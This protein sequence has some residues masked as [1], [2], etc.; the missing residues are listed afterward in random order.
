[1]DTN[2]QPD[3]A[4]DDTPKYLALAEA[5]RRDVRASLLRPG[6][7]LPPVRD[8]AWRIGVTPGTVARAYR[9]GIDQGLLTASVGRGTFV[10]TPGGDYPAG[11]SP[12]LADS[13]PGKLDL[14]ACVTPGVGQDA[15]IAEGLARLS[16]TRGRRYVE[17]PRAGLDAEARQA[18]CDWAGRNGIAAEPSD[19][20][21][22]YGAQNAVTVALQTILSGP[23]PV[24]LTEEVAFPGMR[25]AARILRAEIAGV[26]Q[27]DEG[28]VPEAI[29]A[30]CRKLHPQV[31]LTSSGAHNP[32]T[33]ETSAARRAEIAELARRFD[34][35]IVEDDAYGLVPSPHPMYRSL[36][37][38]RVWYAASLTKTVAAGLRFGYLVCPP[39]RGQAARDTMLCASYGLSQIVADL[40]TELITSGQADQFRIRCNAAIAARVR[41]TV[42]ALGK[43][44]IRWREDAPFCWLKLPSGWRA[45]GFAAAC[46]RSGIQIRPADEFVLS[47]GHAPNAV[48]IAV[49][50]NVAAEDFED[51]LHTLAALLDTPSLIR[52]T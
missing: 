16:A 42:E 43:W 19:V 41:L 6:D 15:A 34:F 7:K 9:Q 14:R 12:A 45:S 17:H 40:G 46:D 10:S 5:I 32:T 3:L 27:D 24:I 11:G 29:E 31:F 20:A 49:N 26:A 39:G 47:D 13:D 37:P 8:L 50:C 35:Q 23:A 28:P 33:I 4:T 52:G 25:H 2:W 36:A 21:L 22:T 48:R 44:D 30:A 38:E 51:G 18:A 1:M